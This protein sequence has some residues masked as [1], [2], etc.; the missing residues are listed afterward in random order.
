MQKL[1]EKLPES[2]VQFLKFGIV[3]AINTVLS[4]GINNGCYYVFHM[5]EQI[6]NF[7]AFVITVFISFVLN[8]KFVFDKDTQEKQPWY[9][10]LAKVYASYA[11]TELVLMGVLLYIQERIFGIPH[12]VATLVNLCVTVPLN[13][14]LNKFWAYKDK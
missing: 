7:I 9:K 11:L 8:S 12:F 4:Y 3:G 5:H 10:A 13:F 6:S 14:I 1:L 2:L